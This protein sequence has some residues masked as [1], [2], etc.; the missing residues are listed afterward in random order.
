M[1]GADT[2]ACLAG[3]GVHSLYYF[4]KE[5]F[6]EEVN[7]QFDALFESDKDQRAELLMSYG[8][9]G[10]DQ[11]CVRATQLWLQAMGAVVGDL[12]AQYLPLGGMYLTGGMFAKNAE[13]IQNSAV[14]CGALYTKAPHINEFIAQVPI[15]IVKDQDVGLLG[16]RS[17]SRKLLKQLES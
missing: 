5:Q 13:F 17:C 8:L 11:L 14:F 16:A 1:L 2:E 9:T 7:A 4:F 15:H 10:R 6:P 12:A 3:V